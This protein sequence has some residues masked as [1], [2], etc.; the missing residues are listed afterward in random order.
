MERTVTDLNRAFGVNC[1]SSEES[2]NLPAIHLACLVYCSI[3]AVLLQSTHKLYNMLHQVLR[4]TS[5]YTASSSNSSLPPPTTRFRHKHST[6]SPAMIPFLAENPMRNNFLQLP[7]LAKKHSA[8]M[9]PMPKLMLH[10]TR[11]IDSD[12]RVTAFGRAGCSQ[13]P[14]PYVR[15][16][17]SSS[18]EVREGT[19][20]I[21][22]LLIAL[23]LNRCSLTFA[24]AYY[25]Q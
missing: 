6:A 20:A 13:H 15:G 12:Y 24:L 14:A 8:T 10:G 4:S 18:F 19:R 25:Q 16:H 2:C 23:E 3:A 5:H 9:A 7:C 17:K 22:V 1:L 11:G 21:L